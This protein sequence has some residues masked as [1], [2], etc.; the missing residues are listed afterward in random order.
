MFGIKPKTNK[1]NNNEKQISTLGY[2]FWVD[3]DYLH[4]RGGQQGQSFR[5]LKKD[6]TSVSI[7]GNPAKGV[8]ESVYSILKVN[9]QGTLLGQAKV[10][11]KFVLKAQDFILEE[12]IKKNIKSDSPTTNNYIDELERLASLKE[13]GIIT[14]EDFDAKKKQLLNL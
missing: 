13:K 8:L 11:G 3:D 6:I 4:Y 14:Q 12:V 10:P 9:G 2:K 7:D 1:V 5:I